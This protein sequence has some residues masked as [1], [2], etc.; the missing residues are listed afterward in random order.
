MAAI[1]DARDEASARYQ[2]PR[3]AAPSNAFMPVS[4]MPQALAVSSFFAT[5]TPLAMP[6]AEARFVPWR[7]GRCAVSGRRHGASSTA[8]AAA[9]NARHSGRAWRV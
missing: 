9:R 2:G 4:L 5:G 7:D 1:S 6:P 3:M 8:C